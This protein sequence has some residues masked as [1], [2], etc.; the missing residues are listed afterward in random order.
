MESREETLVDVRRAMAEA[1]CLVDGRQVDR[2]LDALARQITEKLHD[3]DP[4]V[5]V[6]MNGGL[7]LAGRLLPKLDFPLQLSYLHAS[8]YGHSLNGTLLD[9]RVRPT[10][11]LRG[12][13]VLVLD[14]I[15]DEGWMLQAILNFFKDEG[16]AEVHSAVLI[17]K[18]HERKA[19]PGMRADFTGIDVAD[20][21]LFG[22]GMDYKGYWRNA[23]G[24]Y[25][26]KGC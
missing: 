18:I 26:L 21:F 5:F 3:K 11:D 19:Y 10:Q 17:H 7:V 25:A 1:E 20:R 4:L 14:D 6:V 8:R 12:R 16:A 2:A 15:L 23:P 13:T 9:W 22:C 24:I